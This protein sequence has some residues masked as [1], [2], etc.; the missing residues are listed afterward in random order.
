ML[1][2][3]LCKKLKRMLFKIFR[4]KS[5]TS[6]HFRIAISLVET[7]PIDIIYNLRATIVTVNNSF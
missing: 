2:I 1:Y 7:F 5:I 3:R 6:Y 4:T